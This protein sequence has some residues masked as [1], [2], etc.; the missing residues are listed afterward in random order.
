MNRTFLSLIFAFVAVGGLM[1]FQA[2]RSESSEVVLPSELQARTKDQPRIR[3]AGKVIAGTIDYTLQPQIV[4]RFSIEN[5]GEGGGSLPV[6]YNGLKP[7]MFAPGRDVIIDGEYEGGVMKASKLLTQCPS[8]YE[9]P[10][11]NHPQVNGS[12]PS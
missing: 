11:P 12:S 10:D 6:V 9:P 3:V 7:D 1:V 4:L 2:T 5:P 8:K